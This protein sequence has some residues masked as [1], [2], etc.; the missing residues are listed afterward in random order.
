MVD[1]PEGGDAPALSVGE[2]QAASDATPS[3]PELH[4]LYVLDGVSVA[5]LARRYKVRTTKVKA[6]LA[7]AGIPIRP[8][9]YGQSHARRHPRPTRDTLYEEFV[10]RRTPAAVLAARYGVNVVTVFGW[11]SGYGISAEDR[12]PPSEQL[13]MLY[14]NR[15]W[16]IATIAAACGVSVGTAHRWLRK[17]GVPMRGRAVRTVPCCRLPWTSIAGTWSWA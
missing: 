5:D 15:R 9:G 17:A 4:H 16:D 3:S 6:W 1:G 13:H 12:T 7:D 2:R 11:L 14:V 8:R 10:V